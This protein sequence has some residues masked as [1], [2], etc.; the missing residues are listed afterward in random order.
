MEEYYLRAINSSSEQLW[1]KK[2]ELVTDMPSDFT[3]LTLRNHKLKFSKKK[4]EICSEIN[5]SNKND[6]S[7]FYENDKVGVTFITFNIFQNGFD[8][9][10]LNYLRLLNYPDLNL[11]KSLESSDKVRKNLQRGIWVDYENEIQ[12]FA[13]LRRTLLAHIYKTKNYWRIKDIVNILQVSRNTY[14]K[15]KSLNK[16]SQDLEIVYNIRKNMFEASKKKK[17]IFIKNITMSVD[18]MSSIAKDQLNKLKKYYL[19]GEIQMESVEDA[20][21]P[22]DILTN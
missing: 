8:P 6:L 14:N 13:D 20:V 2:G 12:T 9:N 4:W 7:G 17:E 16:S 1:L 15:I 3:T 21:V 19:G 22:Y 5:C 11:N 10:M 18:K